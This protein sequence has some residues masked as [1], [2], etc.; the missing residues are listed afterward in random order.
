MILLVSTDFSNAKDSIKQT[1]TTLL[2]DKRDILIAA[3]VTL[4]QDIQVDPDKGFLISNLDNNLVG[5]DD[6]SFITSNALGYDLEIKKVENYLITYDSPIPDLTN[7][8]YDKILK[9]VQY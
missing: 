1:V 2:D 3:I 8:L 5:N 9:I 4:I 6:H 7:K